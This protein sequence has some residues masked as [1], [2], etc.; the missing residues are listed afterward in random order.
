MTVLPLPF[1]AI[2]YLSPVTYAL[3]GIRDALLGNASIGALLS[4]VVLLLGM[5]ALLIG[6]GLWVFGRAEFRAKRLGLL[7]RNG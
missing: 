3:A 2:G 4:T 1:Q 7:K 5:G 6:G